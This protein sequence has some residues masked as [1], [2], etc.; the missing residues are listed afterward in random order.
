MALG[1]TA[2]KTLMGPAF[3]VTVSRGRIF[4]VPGAKA[5]MATVH[6]SSIL[7]APDGEREA[8]FKAFVA[9]LKKIPR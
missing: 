6:P 7:R 9:D 2:A 4:E 8:Q 3:R 5:F 1:A